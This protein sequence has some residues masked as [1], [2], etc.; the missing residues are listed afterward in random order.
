MTSRSTYQVIEAAGGGE[1]LI[2]AAGLTERI[3]LLLTDV[4]MP[5]LSGREV[6]THL[7]LSNPKLKV[8][9]MSG[10][11]DDVISPGDIL[12]SGASL[13]RKPFGPQQL[14]AEVRAVLGVRR[15]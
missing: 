5:K 15:C 2:I 14:A 13:I 9:Y 1:A 4:V 3:D 7:R 8:L 6:A 11:A 12:S 10:Y